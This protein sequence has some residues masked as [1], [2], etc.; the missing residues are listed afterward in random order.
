MDLLMIILILLFSLLISNI[1]SHYVPSIPT[2]LIQIAIGI[3]LAILFEG[4]PFQLETEWFLL[5]FIAPL[6]YNDGRRFSREELWEMRVPIL[7][8]A[9]ILVI[10]TTVI[11]GYFIHWMIPDIPLTAAF[12][13][14][15]ILSPT[16][17]VAV[18]GI[19]KRIQIPERILSLVKGESLINDAS[20]LVAFNYAVAAV[21][22]SYFSIQEAIFD[23]SYKFLAGVV[24]GFINGFL[25]TWLRFTLRKQG[26]ND[27]TFHS[28][29]QILTPFIIY[30]VTEKFFHA[31][32]I[33][34]VVVAG[35]LH[36]LV[37][38]RTET[39][40]A[41]EQVLTE[42]IW[43]IVLFIL[44]GLVFLLL[45][46]NIP[47][48]IAEALADPNINNW[49]L[50]GYVIA[51]GLVILVIRLGWSYL[52]FSHYYFG[53]SKSRVTFDFKTYLVISLTGVR[54]TVTMAG[55]FSVPYF[56]ANGNE[57]PQ[58]PLILFVA[59]GVILFTLAA[60][61]IFLPVLSNRKPARN[62][63]VNK[64]DISIA[65]RKIMLEAIK[66]IRLEM[67]DENK[68]AAYELIDE[69]KAMIRRIH[70]EEDL[71]DTYNQEIKEIR[72][73]A[74]KK[75]R[76]YIHAMMER[77]E[78]SE[79]VF[80]IAEK[81]L[82]HREEALS[83]TAGSGLV[84]LIGKIIRTWSRYK[85]Q[86]GNDRTK[87]EAANLRL[88]KDI[89]LK[90]LQAAYNFLGEYAKKHEKA[91]LVYVV[92]IDY[93]KMIDRLKTPA[94]R[95]NGRATEQKEEMHIKVMDI[96]RSEIRRMFEAGEISM[97]QAKELRRFVNNIESVTLYEYIE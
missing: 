37:S 77:H 75:E 58:R 2:A 38:E 57:F 9:I 15:A 12:A 55:V 14:A 10:L 60:A 17:P 89:H 44:N 41:E 48:S 73:V 88:S 21:I 24:L 94:E 76:E 34:A 28:L 92:I 91:N 82:D 45:G 65:K 81:V 33:I 46:L 6:L 62:E 66:R 29:L 7:G 52:F 54:G 32:G 51:T 72:L 39:I 27:V 96:E 67:N 97:E 26:I 35:I 64:K 3:I 59:A 13:L 20:G 43:I 74:L 78:I 50:I 87:S 53:K 40:I 49:M 8:N 86:S 4:N 63:G 69:Y 31:S 36:S 1:V 11:G 25:V 84:Y 56:V 47:S 61:T 18:T 93:K 85:T 90:A 30:I 95:Y 80:D 68:F 71:S 22:T 23:F 42:H 79:A 83:T 70:H 5:L 19:A 16:D